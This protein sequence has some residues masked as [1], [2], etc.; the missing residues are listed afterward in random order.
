MLD[1]IYFPDRH[2]GENITTEYE[3]VSDRLG[4]KPFQIVTDKG[5]NMKLGTRDFLAKEGIP[6]YNLF[7]FLFFL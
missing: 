1:L 4:A 3:K 2:T 6:S 7:L 5:A